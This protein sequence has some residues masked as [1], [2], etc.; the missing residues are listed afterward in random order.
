[1]TEQTLVRPQCD[2][3]YFY[4]D[5]KCKALGCTYNT[6]VSILFWCD[7]W[8]RNKTKMKTLK[9]QMETELNTSLYLCHDFNEIEKEFLRLTKEWLIQKRQ[10]HPDDQ[11]EY[12][13]GIYDFI[14][15][16]L[17]DLKQ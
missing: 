4:H 1:M 9:Q 16:L 10:K 11:T 13:R 2:N 5:G 3:C 8:I 17:E 12:E 7:K 6:K 14:G 15:E